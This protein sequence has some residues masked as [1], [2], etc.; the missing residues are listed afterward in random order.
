LVQQGNSKDML[1]DFDYI[2]SYISNYFSINIGDL[3]FTG[4]PKGVGEIVVGDEIE[5]SMEN[6]SLLTLDVK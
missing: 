6:E 1:F 3:V 5:A 4:T 2:V